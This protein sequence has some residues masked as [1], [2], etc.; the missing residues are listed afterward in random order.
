[1]TKEIQLTKGYVAIVDDDDF[2]HLSGYRWYQHS[3]GYAVHTYTENG[4]RVQ[5]YMHRVIMKP[6]SG[7]VDHRNRNPLDNR[8]KNL[9]CCTQRENAMNRV[10][11]TGVKYKGVSRYSK[12]YPNRWRANIVVHYKQKWLGSFS[13]QEEAAEAYNKAAIIYFGEY[14]KLNVVAII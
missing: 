7:V 5:L 12:R 14:A 11:K 2:E 8:K 10:G 4:K 3:H 13:S 6:K 9:R 1:M